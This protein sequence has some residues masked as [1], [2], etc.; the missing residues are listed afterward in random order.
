MKSN[1]STIYICSHV[2]GRRSTEG[3][4]TPP[5][6]S[7]AFLIEKP[8]RQTYSESIFQFFMLQKKITLYYV[9]VATCYRN[10]KSKNGNTPGIIR[11]IWAEITPI[12]IAK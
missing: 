6:Q 3:R 1:P 11:Y 4:F 7:P 2:L 12:Q 5:H 8:V 10:F 9:P